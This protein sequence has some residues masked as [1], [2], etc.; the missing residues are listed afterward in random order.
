M[1]NVYLF[2]NVYLFTFDFHATSNYSEPGYIEHLSTLNPFSFPVGVQ[3]RQ[4]P[5]YMY[6]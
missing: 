4:V 3:C 5:L 1:F 6:F 2:K